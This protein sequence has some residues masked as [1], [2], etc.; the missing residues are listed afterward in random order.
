MDKEA[1]KLHGW[2]VWRTTPWQQLTLERRSRWWTGDT[3]KTPA[4]LVKADKITHPQNCRGLHLQRSIIDYVKGSA[5]T[6]MSYAHRA[7]W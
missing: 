1:I 4:P 3:I 7:T 5:M 2:S 6:K